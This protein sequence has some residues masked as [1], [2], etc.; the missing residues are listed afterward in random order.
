MSFEPMAECSAFQ[1]ARLMITLRAVD[2]RPRPDHRPVAM[3]TAILIAVLLVLTAVALDIGRWYVEMSRVQTAADAAALSGVTGC[4]R[5]PTP[6][7]TTNAIEV[8][9]RNGYPKSGTSSVG[10]VP[11]AARASSGHDLEHHPNIFGGIS[12]QSDHDH[13]AQAVADVQDAAPLGSPCNGFGKQPNSDSPYASRQRWSRPFGLPTTD[14]AAGV[15][16]PGCGPSSRAPTRTRGTA[17][18]MRPPP[19]V[20]EALRASSDARRTLRWQSA[21]VRRRVPARELLLDDQGGSNHRGNEPVSVQVYD[22]AYV[23][24]RN[25]SDALE[26]DDRERPLRGQRLRPRLHPTTRRTCSVR[27]TAPVGSTSLRLSCCDTTRTL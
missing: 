17:T 6:N 2:R 24:R 9:A 16:A 15:P 10:A 1:G 19:A 4:R 13:R 23:P 8:S 12:R 11:T 25:C 22:P 3:L 14:L 21:H 26:H 20:R 5:G 27:A 18:G 7:A